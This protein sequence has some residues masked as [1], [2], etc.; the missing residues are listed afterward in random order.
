MSST[1]MSAERNSSQFVNLV[2]KSISCQ[3]KTCSNLWYT[4]LNVVAIN[5]Q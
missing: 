2:D 5:K 1:V 4:R 3:R